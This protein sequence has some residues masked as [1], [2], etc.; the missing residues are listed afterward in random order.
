[1]GPD[2]MV[3]IADFIDRAIKARKDDDALA[4]IAK[5]VAALC[6]KFPLYRERLE[7]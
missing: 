2:E 5:E 6:G 7:A 1:M 4:A 3:K